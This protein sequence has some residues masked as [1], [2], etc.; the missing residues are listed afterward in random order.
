MRRMARWAAAFAVGGI[1]LTGVAGAAPAATANLAGSTGPGPT[2]LGP[3]I[4]APSNSGIP[5]ITGTTDGTVQPVQLSQNWSGYAVTSTA[6]TPTSTFTSV[7]GTFDQPSVVCNGQAGR[8]VAAWVGLDGFKDETVEQDGTFAT[9][10]G[11]GDMT[12]TYEAWYEMYPADSE[13]V[14]SVNA[15]D[16]IK[17]SVTFANGV[18]SLSIADVTSGASKTFS[19]ACKSCRRTSA[20][21]IIE[22]PELCHKTGPCFLSPLP[23]FD[24][25]SLSSDKAATE[26][27]GPEPLSAYSPIPMDM[28]QPKGSTVELLDQTN[29]L[30]GAGTAFTVTWER[31]GKK[32]PLS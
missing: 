30:N 13:V 31:S 26:A 10:K 18:F 21:W 15:G 23:D 1:V 32:L 25:A 4:P 20:E 8:Y 29:P 24:V 7:E 14:F 19:A 28:I 27:G 11:P 3:M 9:C 6:G 12:P 16:V 5:G 22:R 17:S 2:G